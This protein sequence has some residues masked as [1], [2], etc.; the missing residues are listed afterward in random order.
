MGAATL[1]AGMIHYNPNKWSSMFGVRGS[2]LPV[3][4]RTATLSVS[5]AHEISCDMTNYDDLA[6]SGLED[7][8]SMGARCVADQVSGALGRD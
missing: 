8:A 3:S 5:H 4:I 6:W 1:L 2:V 7:I